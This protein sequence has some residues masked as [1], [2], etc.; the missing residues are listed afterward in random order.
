MQYDSLLSQWQVQS[1]TEHSRLL[2]AKRQTHQAV[3]LVSFVSRNILPPHP[4][5]I[6]GNLEWRRDLNMFLG[7]AIP[8]RF[9]LRAGLR[10][11]D[12]SLHLCTPQGRSFT[13]FSLDGKTF[14]EGFDWLKA[15]VKGFGI[16][17]SA[18]NTNIPYDIPDYP[19][20][21]GAKFAVDDAE[22]FADFARTYS[23][24]SLVLEHVAD[25]HEIWQHVKTWPHH[26]DISSRRRFM[27]GDQAAHMGVGYSPGDDHNYPEPYWHLTFSPND[28][29]DKGSL[30]AFAS[31]LQWQT[32]RWLGVVLH[33]KNIVTQ[34]TAEAQLKQVLTL[35]DE[36]M[37][38][39][40]EVAV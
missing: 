9:D 37:D 13:S 11:T 6:F 32:E 14:K 39:L 10:V 1:I 31:D 18:M 25:L 23:N 35:V 2:N 28:H 40:I 4:W 27:V 5:D 3:Q 22:A 17:S 34:T 36:G 29:V 30:P 24:A 19:Q 15:Q 8:G 26:F 21:S 38:K 12:L 33:W 16:N 20:A 7:W